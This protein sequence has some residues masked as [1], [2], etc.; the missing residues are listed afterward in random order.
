MPVVACIGEAAGAAAAKS[1]KTG[2]S[3]SK[4]DGKALKKEILG[5]G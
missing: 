3:P 5:P 4:L 2:T 1:A